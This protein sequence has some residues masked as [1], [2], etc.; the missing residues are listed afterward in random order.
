M[1]DRTPQYPGRVRL[2]P[3]S[4]QA[5]IYDLTRADAPIEE[6]T[7]LNKKTLLTD[8]T[9][10]LLEL[11]KENPT[12]DDAFAHIATNFVGDG[13]MNINL[14]EE[15]I[16]MKYCKVLTLGET[17]TEE[18]AFLQD[19]VWSLGYK[20]PT[21][22]WT[23][24]AKNTKAAPTQIQFRSRTS[25]GAVRDFTLELGAN[26]FYQHNSTIY[27][28]LTGMD[29]LCQVQNK[30]NEVCFIFVGY[31][32]TN[33]TSGSSTA[34]YS[35]SWRIWAVFDVT[36]GAKK[37]SS[38]AY[39]TNTSNASYL[40]AVTRASMWCYYNST[41]S[42]YYAPYHRRHD[43]ADRAYVGGMPAGHD[44]LSSSYDTGIA[45]LSTFYMGCADSDN[46]YGGFGFFVN[47]TTFLYA[48]IQPGNTVYVY[49]G[50]M[51]SATSMS[52]TTLASSTAIPTFSSSNWGYSSQ[53]HIHMLKTSSNQLYLY[54][55]GRASSTTT[56]EYHVL[57]RYGPFTYTMSSITE[58]SHYKRLRGYPSQVS[59]S[60][61]YPICNINND[62]NKL[63]FAVTNTMTN[64][65]VQFY[66]EASSSD[67]YRLISTGIYSGNVDGRA[68]H[69]DAGIMRPVM[70]CDNYFTWCFLG[71]YNRLASFDVPTVG[72][73][74]ET[75]YWTCPED[76]RY[77]IIM[78]GG[79]AA[80]GAS[81]GGGSGYLKIFVKQYYEGDR[82]PYAVGIGEHIFNTTYAVAL[83]STDRS[84]TFDGEIA[85]C[86]S[87]AL[88]GA[89]GY[90]A[91]D[92][93]GGGGYNLVCYGGS[94]QPDGLVPQLNGGQGTVAD[95]AGY[96]AGG[97]SGRDGKDGVI[98]IL[99]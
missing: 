62:A 20:H 1:K 9:A 87:G 13:G 59:Y 64:K 69:P 34:T 49:K 53:Q 96:G 51:S 17:Q 23:V 86:G 63:V 79:G 29:F 38:V 95:A 14:L 26:F 42:Y 45:A 54:A 71:S 35:T 24:V 7:P 89:P 84:S 4:G 85:R 97:A 67:V 37:A 21:Q 33:Y 90:A 82:V 65:E 93:G 81:Y 99:R 43:A 3:V 27:N 80:G 28:S 66:Q 41:Y 11:K 91:A 44:Y 6:G 68:V 70:C 88:G 30:N 32:S 57:N 52:S 10:Y 19:A 94:G 98:V 16:N 2:T 39:N 74:G 78:V 83:D 22:G 5:D 55:V 47:N 56:A 58:A 12:P 31:T 76:G 50:T 18:S 61:M 75:K 77:K 46:S 92:G 36:T 15:A 48:R 60:Y 25:A 73:V 8:E 72:K 40:Y